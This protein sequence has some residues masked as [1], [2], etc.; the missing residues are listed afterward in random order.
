MTRQEAIE[1]HERASATVE[2]RGAEARRRGAKITD[3]PYRDKRTHSG[4]LTFS[5]AWR[6]AW[7]RGWTRADALLAPHEPGWKPS[8]AGRVLAALD[9]STPETERT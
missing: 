1:R 2:R 9:E 6:N 5:R 3:C 4:K 8:R 7:L